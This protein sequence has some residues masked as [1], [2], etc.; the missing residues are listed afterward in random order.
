MINMR[1]PHQHRRHQSRHLPTRPRPTRSA[2][3]AHHRIHQSFQ[4]QPIPQRPGYQQPRVGYQS[5][6]I[7]NN[8]IPVNI[9]RYSTHRKYLLAPSQKPLFRMAIVPD[10]RHFPRLPTP[11]QP[12]PHR[13]IQA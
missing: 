13:W 11:N 7:E 2:P 12:N 10:Q 9:I 8:P 6:I 4:P 5:L 1:T 3:Q